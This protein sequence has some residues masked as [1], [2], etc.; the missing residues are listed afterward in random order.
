MRG[1]DDIG[2]ALVGVAWKRLDAPTAESGWVPL[3]DDGM[4]DDGGMLDG[5]FAGT[6][7]SGFPDGAEVEFFV[8]GFDLSDT[9]TTLPGSAMFS[10]PGLPLRNFSM[11]IGSANQIS[12]GLQ[13]SE[14]VAD[15]DGSIVDEGGQAVDWIEVRNAGDSGVLLD[16]LALAQSTSPTPGKVFAF[17][18]G[19]VLESGEYLII[20]ADD[21]TDQGEMHAP[22]KLSADGETV[23]L[24]GQTALGAT[25]VSDALSWPAL[26]AGQAYAAIGRPG[27]KIERVQPPTPLAHNLTSGTLEIVPPSAPGRFRFAYPTAI[28]EGGTQ[29]WVLEVSG[30][31]G[32]GGWQAVESGFSGGV[33]RLHEIE[34]TPG[35]RK[36]FRVRQPE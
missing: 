26:G 7:E 36:F 16:G 31:L 5:I 23:T 29:A 13:I 6:L 4:H 32:A 35:Q 20:W 12:S 10:A 22:F 27:N 28:G 19:T 15:N 3:Y 24:I 25:A 2:L 9:S 1:R 11:A 33:E 14:V 17:P 34:I 8:Q 30:S 21:D 18:A